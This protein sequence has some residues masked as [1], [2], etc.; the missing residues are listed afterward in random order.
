MRF[1]LSLLHS[2]VSDALKK[3]HVLGSQETLLATSQQTLEYQS[4]LLTM[5]MTFRVN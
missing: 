2:N 4:F 5:P 1:H 3:Y